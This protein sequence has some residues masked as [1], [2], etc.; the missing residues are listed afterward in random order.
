[1]HHHAIR[2]FGI[3]SDRTGVQASGVFAVIARQGIKCALLM[4]INSGIQRVDIPPGY[5][6]LKLVEAFT[7]H[8]ATTAA[9][10][11]ITVD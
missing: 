5:L 9:D 4:G 10:A 7:C 11:F 2:A 8:R 6:R 3:G 1:M